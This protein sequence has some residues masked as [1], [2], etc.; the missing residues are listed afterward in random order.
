MLNWVVRG[1]LIVAGVVT[2][3]FVA[4]DATNFG[5]IQMMVALLLLTLI[6]AVIA[7]WPDHWKIRPHQSE[8][9]NR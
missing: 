5:V 7:F 4:K 2:G 1:L 8:K 3:W 9:T 6:I